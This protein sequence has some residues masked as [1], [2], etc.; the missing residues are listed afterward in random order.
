MVDGLAVW[1]V[2]CGGLT[3]APVWWLGTDPQIPSPGL[4]P[5]LGNQGQQ[6]NILGYI[7]KWLNMLFSQI[8]YCFESCDVSGR[9]TS[10]GVH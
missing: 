10:S 1:Y 4:H 7:H 9:A 8:N 2:W 6:Y 5:Y 3:Q